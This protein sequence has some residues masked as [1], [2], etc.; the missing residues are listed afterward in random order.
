MSNFQGQGQK[1]LPFLLSSIHIYISYHQLPYQMTIEVLQVL[2]K[3]L[4]KGNYP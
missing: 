3:P 4:L 2:S 1:T